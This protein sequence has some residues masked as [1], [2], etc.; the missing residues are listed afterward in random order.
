MKFKCCK[1]CANFGEFIGDPHLDGFC[2]KG[3]SPH[4]IKEYTTNMVTFADVVS[5]ENF[6]PIFEQVM[7]ELTGE[8]QCR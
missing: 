7:N 2:R 6:E 3:Y 1:H 8:Y 5:C 4:N